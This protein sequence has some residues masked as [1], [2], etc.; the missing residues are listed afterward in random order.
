MNKLLLGIL[1]VSLTG[2]N[3]DKS[4][5]IKTEQYRRERNI[6]G[7]KLAKTVWGKCYTSWAGYTYILEKNDGKFL[8]DGEFPSTQFCT[9]STQCDYIHKTK[10]VIAKTCNHYV[11]AIMLESSMQELKLTPTK[12]PKSIK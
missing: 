2:C 1:L 7:V 9:L 6:D 3:N 5:S 11:M 10:C 8:I 12:C 4:E